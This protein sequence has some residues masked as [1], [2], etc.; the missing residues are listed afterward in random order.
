[1][2]GWGYNN[3]QQLSHSQEF[4]DDTNPQ[5]ALLSPT[6]IMGPLAEMFVV[7]AGAGE[8]FS[9]IVAQGKKAGKI[10]EHVYAC[11]NN[12]KGQLGIN[13]TSH[14][15]D[16]TRVDDLSGIMDETGQP[17]FIDHL[18]CGRR[19]C[20]ATH[21]YGGFKY[22]GDNNLGQL[23]NRRRSFMESPFPMRKFQMK[24]NV[25]NVI[26]ALDSCAVIVEDFER[27]KKKKKNKN[28]RIL[29]RSEL[30]T[31]EDEIRR[32]TE[33]AIVKETAKDEKDWKGR[34]SMSDRFRY[35]FLKA[36]WG[37]SL[38]TPKQSPS[39]TVDPDQKTQQ[40]RE[41]DRLIEQEKKGKD[42]G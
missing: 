2:Y 27:E 31:S 15:Q 16:L 23:G 33:A 18:Q 3:Q 8:E 38:G 30:V 25:E 20:I 32:R 5:H 37:D 19:H 14:V 39:D 28:K 1:M 40:V 12:L 41:L 4:A 29:K 17:R 11:G 22:W 34:N 6:R 10:Y 24:H 36:L 9:I 21:D 7:D 42:E 35:G 13:R 26:V